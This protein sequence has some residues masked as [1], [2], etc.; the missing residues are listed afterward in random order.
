MKKWPN[1]VFLQ[2]YKCSKAHEK[3]P[4]DIS[5]LENGKKKKKPKPQ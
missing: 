2:V 4:Q 1:Y 5:H 3:T